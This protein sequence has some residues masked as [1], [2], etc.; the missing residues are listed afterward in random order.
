MKSRLEGRQRVAVPAPSQPAAASD[1]AAR[2]SRWAQALAQ[3]A[4]E[5]RKRLQH[6]LRA[7]QLTGGTPFAGAALHPL[8]APLSREERAQ[9]QDLPPRHRAHFLA[10]QVG[11]TDSQVA[12]F[13]CSWDILWRR[14]DRQLALA[15]LAR[16]LD[17]A[18]ESA[19]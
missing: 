18:K 8:L 16:A 1:Q 12:S 4:P 2:R 14:G 10:Q 11:F 15:E 19:R 6:A 5:R 3:L 9:Y 17:W 13:R 7:G